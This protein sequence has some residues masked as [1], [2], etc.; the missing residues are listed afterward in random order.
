MAV[1]L[2]D[3]N[4]CWGFW[5]DFPANEFFCFIKSIWSGS[6]Y[7]IPV[8]YCIPEAASSEE[9]C[10]SIHINM[11][12]CK[13]AER[14]TVTIFVLF[15]LALSKKGRHAYVPKT[16]LGMLLYA[17]RYYLKILLCFFT[18]FSS[19]KERQVTWVCEIRLQRATSNHIKKGIIFSNLKF[20]TVVM[21]EGNWET[22][23]LIWEIYYL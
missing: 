12:A 19:E 9:R 2:V 7:R 4:I 20:I 18:F 14:N 13:L 21:N 6:N 17:Y 23:N 15:I 3:C 8:H 10:I 1:I 16:T 11:I 22:W 5:L